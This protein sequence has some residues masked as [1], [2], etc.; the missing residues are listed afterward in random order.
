[1]TNPYLF[2]IIIIIIRCGSGNNITSNA[3]GGGIRSGR[4]H[5]N[6]VN[7][8]LLQ[9]LMLLMSLLPPLPTTMKTCDKDNDNDNNNNAGND[10]GNLN[11][12]SITNLDNDNDDIF[13][14]GYRC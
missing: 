9:M 13:W 14:I 2:T 5:N 6:G 12:A 8:M 10:H 1:M 3:F 11:N 7:Y 4:G